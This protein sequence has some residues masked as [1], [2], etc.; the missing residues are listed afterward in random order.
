MNVLNQCRIA[1]SYCE[2]PDD[3]PL[4]K[5]IYS[6][7]AQTTIINTRLLV[8]KQVHAKT[9]SYGQRLTYELWVQNQSHS[10][11][12]SLIFNDELSE[13]AHYVPQ[14][15]KVND[16]VVHSGCLLKNIPLPALLPKAKMKLTFEVEVAICD[17]LPAVSNTGVITY[18]HYYSDEEL[19]ITVTVRSNTTKTPITSRLVQELSYYECGYFITACESLD[20]VIIKSIRITETTCPL[21][22]ICL[23]LRITSLKTGV[24]YQR[25][26]PIHLI[27]TRPLIH[28][29]TA[30]VFLIDSDLQQICCQ[31]Q[32]LICQ[33]VLVE[34]DMATQQKAEC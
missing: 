13:N 12:N 3:P 15:F 20:E 31:K 18:H 27:P 6:N 28:A 11:L 33:F 32:K 30:T 7:L 14:T 16:Q 22:T 10:L 8:T 17:C 1:Y 2:T 24:S 19:P 9:A 4:R 29:S 34:N 21:I 25:C 5:T 26:Y 23:G